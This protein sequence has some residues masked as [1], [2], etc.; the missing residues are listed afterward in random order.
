ML[1][2]IGESIAVDVERGWERAIHWAGERWTMVALLGG[3]G[4]TAR[5]GRV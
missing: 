2:G 5:R 3:E 4:R 1:G